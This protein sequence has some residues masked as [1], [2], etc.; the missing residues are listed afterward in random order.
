MNTLRLVFFVCAPAAA[1][2]VYPVHDSLSFVQVV[3]STATLAEQ[4]KA[5]Q[6]QISNQMKQ[7]EEA[8]K[9][10]TTTTDFAA[11]VGDWKGVYDRAKSLQLSAAKLGEMPEFNFGNAFNLDYTSSPIKYT[12]NG[13]YEPINVKNA[14]GQTVFINKFETARYAAIEQAGTKL[15]HYLKQTDTE[16]VELRKELA[17]TF[18]DMNKKGVTQAEQQKLAQKADSLNSR[19]RDIQND[20]AVGIQRVQLQHSLN[21]NQKEKEEAV[22]EKV[23]DDNYSKLRDAY[24]QTGSGIRR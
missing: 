23:A 21:E 3:K 14:L 5:A 4:L 17:Q 22:K 20:R 2:A 11:Q 8:K 15:D 6:D 18:E 12:G 13:L 9:L 16:L 1:Y 10:Y 7:I 24:Q 19:I